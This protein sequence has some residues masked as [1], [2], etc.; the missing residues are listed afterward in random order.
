MEKVN[1]KTSIIGLAAIAL[2]TTAITANATQINT[3]GND[4][5]A[6]IP[7]QESD[8]TYGLPGIVNESDT[9]VVEVVGGVK[10]E[11]S[12]FADGHQDFT[13]NVMTS[14]TRIQGDLFAVDATAV[15]FTSVYWTTPKNEV[16]V[17]GTLSFTVTLPPSVL[18]DTSYIAGVV[19]LPPH[20]ELIG[21]TAD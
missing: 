10:R 15:V 17:N 6:G 2:T 16:P 20:S 9:D 7:S 11:P 13:F 3:P 19:F 5:S 4:F 12:T 18:D 8:L 14:A 21:V 1:M